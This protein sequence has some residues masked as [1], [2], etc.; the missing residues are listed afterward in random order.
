MFI[1]VGIATCVIAFGVFLGVPE[2]PATCKWLTEEERAVCMSHLAKSG[3]NNAAHHFSIQVLKASL[4]DYKVL[5]SIWLGKSS[6]RKKRKETTL[7][8]TLQRAVPTLRYLASHSHS[9]QS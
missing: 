9:L 2:H 7:K 1:L 4:S 8:L 6:L 5:M 3:E